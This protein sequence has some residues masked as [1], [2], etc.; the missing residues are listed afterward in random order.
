MPDRR[1]EAQLLA[2]EFQQGLA[3]DAP[4]AQA[5]AHHLAAGHVSR[6]VHQ[7]Q[8]FRNVEN[9]DRRHHA[10]SVMASNSA[11]SSAPLADQTW[12]MEEKPLFARP[13]SRA[14][15]ASMVRAASCRSTTSKGRT[16]QVISS[17]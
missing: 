7:G 15:A 10:A 14:T 3:A 6:L 11:A 1:F 16:C 13:F 5:G 2:L 9:E 12:S 4:V 8:E 17:E